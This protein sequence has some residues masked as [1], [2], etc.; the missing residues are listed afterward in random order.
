VNPAPVPSIGMLG[1][2]VGQPNVLPCD[3]GV[4]EC[5][6]APALSDLELDAGHGFYFIARQRHYTLN[7]EV[8]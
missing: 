2:A 1:K 4:Y 6:L 8:S 7:A 3:S 5:V